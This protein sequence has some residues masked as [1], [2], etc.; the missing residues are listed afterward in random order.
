MSFVEL[1][2]EIFIV[3]PNDLAFKFPEFGDKQ[4]NGA[5]DVG[6]RIKR[7]FRHLDFGAA[8]GTTR[9]R[10][11]LP[12]FRSLPVPV[13][14]LGEQQRIVAEVE[15][16]LSVVAALDASLEA[17]L[18][19]AERLRQAILKR[20][21]E[22]HLVPQD[23]SDEPASTLLERIQAQRQTAPS[24]DTPRRKRSAKGSR[25][26]KAEQARLL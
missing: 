21:F 10:L 13:P 3:D 16:R 8:F 1:H 5:G 6:C 24:K 7:A 23:P 25:K 9:L 19:R 22:G 20:A 17:N 2:A 18:V 14:P 26:R 4:S 11:T 15:Q 12:I